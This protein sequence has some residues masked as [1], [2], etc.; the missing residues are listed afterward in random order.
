MIALARRCA[1]AGILAAWAALGCMLLGAAFRRDEDLD[2][3]LIDT[4][5]GGALAGLAVA[6]RWAA[7]ELGKPVPP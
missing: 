1:A 3:P 6:A 2:E 5:V 4:A 7:A